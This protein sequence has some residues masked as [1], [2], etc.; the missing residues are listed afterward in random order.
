MFHHGCSTVTDG[1]FPRVSIVPLCATEALVPL[2]SALVVMLSSNHTSILS[3]YTTPYKS[4]N[5]V[6]LCKN[7]SVNLN[8]NASLI[9]DH[10]FLLI[11]I[12]PNNIMTL[13]Q[14]WFCALLQPVQF[15][16]SSC[17]L[18][19][20]CQVCQHIT[21]FVLFTIIRSKFDG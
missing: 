20:W 14:L 12:I 11:P 15:S 5:V 13:D 4:L 18:Q 8:E 19:L 16:A 9:D 3:V 17:V 2:L 7:L 6:I 1:D 10:P 21:C